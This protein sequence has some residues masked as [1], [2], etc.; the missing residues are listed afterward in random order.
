VNHLYASGAD[1]VSRV[2][3]DYDVL[4]PLIEETARKALESNDTRKVQTGPAIRGD[5]A[6][7]ERHLEMLSD[8]ELK[9][10]IYKYITESIWETS[11]KI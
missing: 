11:K 2:E 7:C 3:L 9:Q 10:Q 6:V 5:R 4:K 8:D 1:V